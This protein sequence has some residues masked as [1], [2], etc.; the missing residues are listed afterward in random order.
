MNLD[1]IKAKLILGKGYTFFASLMYG[2]DVHES[3]EV[4]YAATNGIYI[5][6]NPTSMDEWTQEQQL[7]VL[8]HEICHVA[9]EHVII[10]KSRTLNPQILNQ[11]QDYWINDYLT[12]L[13][14][15]MPPVGLLDKKYTHQMAVLEIY[16][17]LLDNPEPEDDMG[18]DVQAPPP[19][20][21]EEVKRKTMTRLVSAALA[22]DQAGE[23]DTIPD[24]IRRTI[25]EY[26][27]P[28]VPWSTFIHNYF[29][30]QAQDEYSWNKRNRRFSDVYIPSMYSL[31]MDKVTAYIDCSV[32]VTE[33][34]FLQEI[35]E[36]SY[37]K[38]TYQPK[39]L[40]L[41]F[42]NHE[43]VSEHTF[44]MED[45]LVIELPKSGGTRIQPVINHMVQ[46]PSDVSLVFSDGEFAHVDYSGI[47][48]PLF[49]IV[50]NNKNFSADVGEVLHVEV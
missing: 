39:E 44:T 12:S 46:H 37:I 28:K 7:F 49:W 3:D 43:I 42:F 27:N 19:E 4:P 16:Q 22:A 24:G 20:E 26:L 2:L 6:L 17:L 38:E 45:E 15:K 8:T 5:K 13:G 33:K 18:G 48:N 47:E 1:A 40:V 9:F 50:I 23:G 31:H 30:S 32:S 14:F 29:N 21:L 10:D 34:E 25:E 41:V 36:L 35:S 11:A